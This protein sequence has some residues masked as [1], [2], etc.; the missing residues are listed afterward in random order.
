M[1]DPVIQVPTV[2][3][4]IRYFSFPY[5]KTDSLE[6]K[7][8][9]LGILKDAYPYIN[10]KFVFK[11]KLQIGSYFKVKESFPILARSNVVYKYTCP[12]CEVGTYIGSTVRLLRNRACNHIGIS[13]RTSLPLSVKEFSSIRKHSQLH[14]KEIKFDDFKILL[15]SR[16]PQSLLILESLALKKELPTLNSDSSAVSLLVA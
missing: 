11:N 5:L 3:K 9:L 10:F 16:D 12:S 14:K 13:H 1:F 4:D 7:E 2:N 15:Q 8:E 6:M